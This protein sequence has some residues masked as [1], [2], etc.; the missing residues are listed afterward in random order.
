MLT[1][2]VTSRLTSK[3]REDLEELGIIAFSVI[4]AAESQACF[5]LQGGYGSLNTFF[6]KNSYRPMV[7]TEDLY[8]SDGR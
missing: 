1:K 3:E 5:Y 6:R 2:V 4:S 8:W 7:S